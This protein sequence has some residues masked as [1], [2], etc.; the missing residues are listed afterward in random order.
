MALAGLEVGNVGTAQ[1]TYCPGFFRLP[2]S[3]HRYRDW[4][5]GGH[6]SVDVKYAI[7]QSCDV[8]FYNLALHLGIDTMHEY[9]NRFGFGTKTGVDLDGERA[10]LYPSQEWKR[11]HRKQPWFP[12]ETLIAG[13]GQGYVQATPIQLAR[14]T[15]ILAN[16]GKVIEPRVLGYMNSALKLPNPFPAP[17][18]SAINIQPGHWR[19]VVDAMI[20]VVHSQAGT[21]K[22]IAPG[23]TYHIAGKTGT[24]QVFTVGQN[25][26]YKKMHVK[27]SLQDHAWFIAFAPAENPKIA[28]AVIA[29]HGGHGGSVAAPIAKAVID[30]YLN[31]SGQL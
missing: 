24:A 29:E 25:Q 14:A 1:R 27:E 23:L 16:Q 9:L 5:K 10:G 4:R 13:I 22:I 28:V 31:S 21:A 30:Q 20:D 7:T 11:K 2:N 3:E 15:A 6:G 8:Y 12:G 17:T 19:T 26:D 18:E